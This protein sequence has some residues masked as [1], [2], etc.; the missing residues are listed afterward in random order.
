MSLNSFLRNILHMRGTKNMC[1]EGGCGV[2]IVSVTVQDP[3]TKKN[4]TMAVNSCLLP[5]YSCYARNITT[6]EGLGSKKSGLSAEQ[7]YLADFS[8]S[9]CGF[10]SPG[11]VMNMHSLRANGKV[12][13]TE[14]EN[15]F[16]GNIC[17]CTGYRPILEAFKALA[18]DAPPELRNKCPDIED[19]CVGSCCQGCVWK[20]EEERALEIK[21]PKATWNRPKTIDDVFKIFNKMASG[22]YMLV[23]GNTAHGVYRR[24]VKP[25][26]YIDT[27]GIEEL[28]QYSVD[29]QL[30]LGGNMTLT[31]VISTLQAVSKEHSS[32]Y[33]YLDEL[34]KHIDLIANVPVRNTGTI[35][36]NLS[37]KYEHRE[38]PSD[39]FLIFETVGAK[40]EIASSPTSVQTVNMQTYLDMDMNR[41]LILKVKLPPL[42]SQYVVR[43]Y[44]IMPRAQNAHA[45]VNAGF[46]FKLNKT[47]NGQVLEKPRI[48]YGGINPTFMHA[49]R[50]EEYLQGKQLFNGNVLK[51]ALRTL[52]S[53]LN[54]DHVLP[55]ASADYRKG[56]AEALFYKFILSLS[57]KGL[58]SNLV[59]GGKILTRP[60]SSAKQKY[61]TDHAQWP[62][63]KPVIKMEAYAQTSGEAEYLDDMPTLPGELHA[64]FVLATEGPGTLKSIDP[65]AALAME[66]VVAFYAADDIPGE[67]N[68]TTF[69]PPLYHLN[70]VE[71]IFSSGKILHAGQPVGLIVAETQEIARAAAA[72][73]K[74]NIVDRKRPVITISD[75]IESGDQ[76]RFNV[77]V[78]PESVD[79]LST[80]SITDTLLGWWSGPEEA[81]HKIKGKFHMNTQYH[82]TMENQCCLCVP[83]ED[84]MDVYSPTMWM[85]Q[86]NCGVAYCLGIPEN[87]INIKV[88]R[89]G[90]G[91]GAKISRS[92]LV[93]CACAVAAYKL[94]RP[95]RIVMSLENNMK[96]IGK[97]YP[98]SVDYEVQCNDKGKIQS[99]KATLYQNS[100]CN[101]NESC[102]EDFTVDGFK[103]GYDTSKW[104][105]T[106]TAVRT[107]IHSNTYA[108][109]PG[110]YEGVVF[111]EAIMEHI[112]DELQLDPIEVRLQNLDAEEKNIP[113]IVEN[114]KKSSDFDKRKEEV[115]KYNKENRWKKRGISMAVMKF[116]IIYFGGYYSLV[117]VYH[118]DGSVAVCHGGIECGQGINTKVAQVAA[119]FLGI[120]LD[121]VIVK[122]SNNLTAPNSDFTGA[123]I[124]SETCAFATM[125][126]CQEILRRLE[127]VK[128]T[129][130]N[131]TWKELVAKGYDENVDMC[132]SYMFKPD[133][134]KE[135]GVEG[136][137]VSEVEVDV[138][139]GQ[140]LVKRVD[141]LENAGVSMSPE[142]DIGQIEGAFIMGLGCVTSEEIIHDPDTGLVLTNRTWNYKVP[143]IKDIPI[144][145][146]VELEGNVAN[147]AGVLRSKTTGE[148][149][150]CL[151]SSVFFAIKRALYAARKDAGIS[152][153]Y[154][155]FDT[156]ATFESTFLHS[157]TNYEQLVL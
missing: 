78:K 100:G 112:A 7:R 82:F 36:G 67:N 134:A 54:P 119:K 149:A 65:A 47:S 16:A 23:G 147:P 58:R 90:G 148:P 83:I 141:I 75:A 44:K 73:V 38:F 40:L 8:G 9:Q 97:R 118:V 64:S 21:G 5:V 98:A 1:L 102:L 18:S 127:P 132:A 131:P 105:I 121:M 152:E 27:C 53:E 49:V 101:Y 80:G 107:D 66:G 142:L 28:H 86:T 136:A 116:P 88:R 109:G 46:C 108:R 126:C 48:V 146:N 106:G 33:S 89:L 13:M 103:G 93:A 95:V 34:A 138:L 12:E 129:M 26:T 96:A 145:F 62:L 56:L 41:K 124:T 104:E 99:L 135:Y 15:S 29:D 113:R 125:K 59:S 25:Q 123:S 63:N 32:Q 72:I 61:Q 11:M 69:D 10:C 43:T 55:D 140:M 60:L 110:T 37:I 51:A 117:S 143:G 31:D 144:E 22:P 77:E 17:R 137:A 45:Y 128:K 57:P 79:A 39:L 3:L 115:E 157:G 153:K 130:T 6:I 50:T 114:L 70:S 91:Y 19:M 2:C 94:N 76:S 154:F 74:V 42:G 24:T 68:F 120:D 4:R 81:T 30:N 156:P 71:E 35:A 139:T 52:H 20:P 87:R 150:I 14:V 155:P 133:D 92:V 84:G 122:P 151:S 111:S 85:D